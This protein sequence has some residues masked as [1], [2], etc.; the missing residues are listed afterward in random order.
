MLA[1]LGGLGAAVCWATTTLVASRAGR[2]IDPL[3]LLASVMTV[4][5]VLSAPVA[6]AAGVPDALDASAAGWLALSGACNI[7]G[8]LCAYEA[9]RVGKVGL[10]API[11]STEGAVAA[12]IAVVA[13]E[14]LSP[15]AGLSLGAIALGVLLAAIPPDAEADVRRSHGRAAVL[16][17][18]A[19]LSFGLGLYSTGHVGQELGVAWAVL[20]PRVVGVAVIAIPLLVLRRWHLPRAAVKFALLGGVAEVVGFASYAYGARHG[21]AVAAVLASQ[22]AAIAAV[23]G[24]LLFRERIAP[25]Q[26]A[27]VVTIVAGVSLL[28]A[29]TA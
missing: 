29:L 9:L 11:T 4:G 23:A 28:S 5:L 12:V 10:V 22:F 21:V 8:L 16:A 18:G 26:V 6:V 3:S 2:L 19:A 13:G 14:S 17:G 1:I 24:F 25:I 7:A 20:P 15:G 27:G